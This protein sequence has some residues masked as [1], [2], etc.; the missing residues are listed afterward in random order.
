MNGKRLVLMLA[1]LIAILVSSWRMNIS[2]FYSHLMSYYSIGAVT[3][4]SLG[5]M[6]SGV[7]SVFSSYLLGGL[8]DRRGP[9]VV[10]YIGALTQ[11][12]SAFVFYPMKFFSWGLS[13][14]MWYAGNVVAGLGATALVL[15]VN[16][17]LLMSFS[18]KPAIALAIAQSAS[19]LALT[20]WSPI[21]SAMIEVFDVFE[22]FLALSIVSFIAMIVCG[23]IYSRQSLYRDS[24]KGSST[25]FAKIPATFI[26]L[27]API[28]FIAM[29]STI[30]LQFLAPITTD[31]CKNLGM[32]STT[33]SR[34]YVPMVMSV[35]GVLQ[36]VGAF[37]WGFIAMRLGVLETLPLLYA[38]EA[39]SMF[40]A[41]SFTKHSIEAVV[42][43]IWLRFLAFGGEPVAHMLLIPKLF[44]QNNMGK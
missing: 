24:V 42:S 43:M 7:A 31:F 32:D 25:T 5:P 2:I 44:G 18:D 13:M 23:I 22:V 11:L 29:S 35:S 40:L 21:I 17:A 8:Y 36:S 33:I 41:I 12:L 27:L 15:S 1:G 3:L 20:M 16:P 26:F 4:L 28:F 30:L 34:S 38:V 19:Y 37:A 39:A 6:L 10:I 14:W 9:S